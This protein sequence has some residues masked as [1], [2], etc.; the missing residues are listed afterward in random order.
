MVIY[1]CAA[2]I[3]ALLPRPGGRGMRASLLSMSKRAYLAGLFGVFRRNRKLSVQAIGRSG[4]DGHRNVE[5][6]DD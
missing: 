4:Q 1:I 3:A 2:V 5:K 6:R